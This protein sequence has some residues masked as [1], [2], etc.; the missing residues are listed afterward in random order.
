[1]VYW[2]V[3]VWCIVVMWCVV[4]L[5]GYWN[6]EVVEEFLYLFVYFC[7]VFVYFDFFGGVDVDDCGVDVFD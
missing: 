1:M 6:V 4:V 3:V 5:V 2:V 7:L